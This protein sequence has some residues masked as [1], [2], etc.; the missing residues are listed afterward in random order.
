MA[1]F[2]FIALII[3]GIIGLIGIFISSPVFAMVLLLIIGASLLLIWI[4]QP[5]NEKQQKK[6]M[7]I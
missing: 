3:L 4:A 6:Q 1:L 7:N 2:G 5:K